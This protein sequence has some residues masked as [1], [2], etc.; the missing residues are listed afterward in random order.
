M[1]SQIPP[2]PPFLKGG[3]GG[4]TIFNVSGWLRGHGEFVFLLLN[5]SI[6][7]RNWLAKFTKVLKIELIL[8]SENLPSPLFAKEG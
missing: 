3:E 7:D 6:K 4:L 1:T 8:A 2:S 5:Q